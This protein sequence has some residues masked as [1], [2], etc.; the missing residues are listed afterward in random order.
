MLNLLRT[1]ILA[2]VT[3]KGICG[4]PHSL[5]VFT[6]LCNNG[7]L[8]GGSSINHSL[9]SKIFQVFLTVAYL[10]RLQQIRT[11]LQWSS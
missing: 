5:H 11:M 3:Q 7:L 6:A 4:A 9:G 1:F 2:V 8:R 10:T